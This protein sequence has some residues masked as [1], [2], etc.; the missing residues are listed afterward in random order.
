[1]NT[2][3][4]KIISTPQSD[5]FVIDN[6][7]PEAI[8]MAQALY[9]RDPRSVTVHMDRIAE[10]GW[11]KFMAS[12]YVG[13]GH[14][15]I[16]D[17]G[18]TTI[19]AEKIS[20]LGAKEIQNWRLYNGQEASTRYIDFTKQEIINPLG[21]TVGEKILAGWMDLYNKTLEHLLPDLKRRFPL[22]D[23]E[24]PATYEKAIKAK[25]FDIGRG[26]LPAGVTT[27]ASWHTNLRQAY[28]HIHIMKHH[29]LDEIRNLA[30]RIE[31]SLKEKYPSSFS[32]KTYD[33]QEK[34][35]AE[36]IQQTAYFDLEKVPLFKTAHTLNIPA[37]S[38]HKDLLSTRPQKTELPS[39]FEK[40]GQ[41][42]FTFGI[43]FGSFRDL[44]R[45][46]SGVC[47]MP[48]LTTTHGFYP[49]YIDQ[50]PENFKKEALESITKLQKDVENLDCDPTI[51]QYYTAI[52]YTVAC[53]VTYGLPASIYTA[54]L[55]SSQ[56]VHPTLRPIAQKMGEFIKIT[57]PGIAIHCDMSEDI[58]T[59]K[60]GQQDIVKKA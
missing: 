32:H 16:G 36:S 28:D 31:N 21:T 40:Y 12:Y 39:Q 46:R 1:M 27:F 58:F 7:N 60:R 2:E 57:V 20:L 22:G 26:F 3:S 50:L 52:G 53:E 5:I 33:D 51:K 18:T 6:L 44:Q 9:S 38:K 14:K 55:R 59:I 24:N 48:L 10:V 8:A 15:S 45:H 30:E 54:E 13:Y 47:E 25:A 49:W 41:I 34:Y 29:P 35:L 23:G 17:C 37:L 4:H 56:T 19:F 43:D 11:Q 42:T